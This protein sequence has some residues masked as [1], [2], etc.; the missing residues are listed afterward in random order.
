MRSKK[1]QRQR[2]NKCRQWMSQ[3]G[4]NFAN[5]VNGSE[6]G[7]DA[8]L[9]ERGVQRYSDGRQHGCPPVSGSLG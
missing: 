4:K 3:G 7:G 2:Y 6:P 9:Q 8:E 1:R 5:G